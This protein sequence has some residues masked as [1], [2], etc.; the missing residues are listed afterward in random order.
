MLYIL[1]NPGY[2]VFMMK[3]NEGITMKTVRVGQRVRT[4]Y[5]RIET[6]VRVE[7]LRIFTKES[8]YNSWFHPTK[9]FSL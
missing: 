4:I 7:P 1:I 9:V 2:I 8:G 3:N 5:G 6:V